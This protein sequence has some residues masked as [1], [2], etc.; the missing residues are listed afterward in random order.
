MRESDDDDKKM[1][2]KELLFSHPLSPVSNLTL[3]LAL[4]RRLES[5][6]WHLRGDLIY[7]ISTF[8]FID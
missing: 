7:A 3:T 8:H 2:Y 5:G 1:S 4:S 6:Q